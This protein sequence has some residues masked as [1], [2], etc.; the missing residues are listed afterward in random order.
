MR[1]AYIVSRFPSTTETFIAREM[2][3]MESLGASI[4]LFA[5]VREH[6]VVVHPESKPFIARLRTAPISRGA[7]WTAQWYWLRQRPGAYLAALWSLVRGNLRSPRFLVRA[8]AVFPMAARFAR[9]ADA[10]RIEHVHAHWA[11][12]PALAAYVIQKLTGISF[13]FTAHAHDI[14]VNRTMLGEKIGAASFVA[15]ISAYNRDYLVSLYGDEIAAKLVLVHCGIDPQRFTPSTKPALAPDRFRLVCVASLQPYKGHAVLIEALAMLRDRGIDAVCELVGEGEERPSI[16][17]RVR[18]LG[19]EASVI[20]AGAKK[21]DEVV[22]IVQLANA[23]VLP[24]VVAADGQMEGIPVA[25][26]EAMAC[27]VAVVAPRLSG[28]PELVV[29]G[30]TGVLV[31]PGDARELADAIERLARDRALR[32]RLGSAGRRHV[33][34][35]FETVTNAK[36]LYARLQ[37]C[38]A[39][40]R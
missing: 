33:Q 8:L 30:E 11:T 13:S 2:R 37:D 38:V 4:D 20:L 36:R 31:T 12:H 1:I 22:A 25:L 15:V 17:R 3:A 9:E 35:E 34:A 29:D 21:S 18:A 16:E 10:Q 27:E 26:M 32:V 24:S 5:L 19:L 40:R 39:D 7:T 6:D 14:F 28:I 23:F